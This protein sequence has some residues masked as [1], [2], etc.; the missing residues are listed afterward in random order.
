VNLSGEA[1]GVRTARVGFQ[2][3]GVVTGVRFREGDLVRQGDVLAELDPREL[4]FHAEIATAQRERAEDGLSRAAL[5]HREGGL[6]ENDFRDAETAV[7]MARAQEGLALKKVDDARLLS[8]FDG[9]VA[10]RS[11]QPGEQVGPGVP[12]FTLVQ[13]DPIWVSVG[14]PEAEIGRVFRGQELTV[15]VPALENQ[16]FEGRLVVVGVAA[17]PVSRTYNVKGEVRNPDR[18]LRPGMIVEAR[19]QT[20]DEASVITVPADAVVPDIDGVTR[21]W[22]YHPDEGRVYSR[23]VTV[24]A[25]V[26]QEVEILAGLTVG[27]QVVVVAEH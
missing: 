20:S 27:D 6:P 19:I 9:V 3:P 1:E 12:V 5:M 24:G 26:D 15:T 13:V 4:Q 18:R 17:D 25:L 11:I 21:V 22:V 8:P 23:R 2:I 14:V 16:R 7:R 10:R